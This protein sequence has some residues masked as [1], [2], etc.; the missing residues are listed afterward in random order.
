MQTARLLSLLEHT[1][2][3]AL[4]VSMAAVRHN[5]ARVVSLCGGDASRWRPHLKTTKLPQIW[6][7]LLDAGVTKFKVAT[8][9]ELEHLGR[10]AAEYA[11]E[12]K[13]NSNDENDGADADFRLDALVA[14]PH[15]GP[16]LDV[17]VATAARHAAHLRVG[18]LVEACHVASGVTQHQD[19]WTS[20]TA[21][22]YRPGDRNPPSP[23]EDADGAAALPADG[24]VEPWL[25]LNPGMDR[26]GV[27]L[28]DAVRALATADA[29]A[30]RFGAGLAGISLYDGHVGALPAGDLR[31][32][33]VHATYERVARELLPPLLARAPACR[34]IVTAGTPAF[35][36][37][38]L[39]RGFASLL[40]HTVS[41]GTVVFHDV[42]T[43]ANNP[44]LGLRPAAHILTRVVSRPTMKPATDEAAALW[45]VTCD[46]GSKAISA[47]DFGG[48]PYVVV[49]GH[50]RVWRATRDVS[51]EH[52]PIENTWSSATS[53]PPARGTPLLLWP[54][55][56]CPSVNL[57]EEAVLVHDDADGHPTRLEVVP[58]AARAHAPWV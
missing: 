12:K 35:E 38:L 3:P 20:G 18:V 31:R 48:E 28:D 26:T 8:P 2:S 15:F 45:R 24:V 49:A 34:E 53:A 57:H 23:L 4:V 58:V 41:P 27:P 19:G 46:A 17:V 1:P 47:E 50:E 54:R 29:C 5:V 7:V 9:R 40:H 39:F 52:L 37:A 55:H 44:G 6:R 13:T 56:V 25:D 51:E 14:F 43:D 32:R 21:A 42:K 10:L 36:A 33:A 30:A 22:R 16:T 11:A